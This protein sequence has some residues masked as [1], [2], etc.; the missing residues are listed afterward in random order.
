MKKPFL[1]RLCP[2]QK[3]AGMIW[4]HASK[5]N[6]MFNP[7]NRVQQNQIISVLQLRGHQTEYQKVAGMVW[8]HTSKENN[9]FNRKNRVQ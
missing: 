4:V 3:G 2:Q 7:K 9:V 5:E 1:K 8:A 6:N